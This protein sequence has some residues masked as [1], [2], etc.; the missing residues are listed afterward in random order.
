[1]LDLVDD[2]HEDGAGFEF[3]PGGGQAAMLKVGTH[4]L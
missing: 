2:F 4:L 1:M 3:L